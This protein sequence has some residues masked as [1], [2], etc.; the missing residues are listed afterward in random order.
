MA[1]SKEEYS[2]QLDFL[3]RLN[4]DSVT[5][6]MHVGYGGAVES[7]FDQLLAEAPPKKIQGS[8]A[9]LLAC[10]SKAKQAW[11]VRGVDL[12]FITTQIRQ[13]ATTSIDM[14]LNLAQQ[15][16]SEKF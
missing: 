1:M 7:T 15:K 6:R 14:F 4:R 13:Q 16:L 9:E 3:L 10:V 2:E 5:T 8:D 12:P 11:F